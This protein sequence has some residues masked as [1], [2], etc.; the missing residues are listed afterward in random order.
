MVWSKLYYKFQIGMKTIALKINN[1]YQKTASSIVF[2]EQY[3]E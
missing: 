1:V 2:K 3:F